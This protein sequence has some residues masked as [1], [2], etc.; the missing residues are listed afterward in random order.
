[1]SQNRTFDFGAFRN[2]SLLNRQQFKVTTTGIYAGYNVVI[3]GSG[4]LGPAGGAIKI[5]NA[6]DLTSVAVSREGV[7]IEESGPDPIIILD[8][9]VAVAT[10]SRIDLVVLQ[11]TFSSSNNPATYAVIAGTPGLNPVPPSIPA[12]AVVLAEVNIG[13]LPITTITNDQIVRR[14]KIL[15]DLNTTGAFRL[16]NL[17]QERHV[18]IATIAALKAIPPEERFD[19]QTVIVDDALPPGDTSATYR[20]D[21][22]SAATADDPIIVSPTNFALGTAGRWIFQSYF[23]EGKFIAM[24]AGNSPTG[25]F[26]SLPDALQ[27][28]EDSFY[29]EALIIIRDDI[30]YAGPD[31]TV[32]KPIKFLGLAEDN[33]T[34]FQGIKLIHESGKLTFDVQPSAVADPLG[35]VEF[36]N[37]RYTRDPLADGTDRII[38]A[39]PMNI[40]FSHCVL[41]D[42]SLATATTPAIDLVGG[43][44]HILAEKTSFLNAGTV[45][46]AL[47]EA[48]TAGNTIRVIMSESSASAVATS[49]GIFKTTGAGV[50]LITM[51]NYSVFSVDSYPN[52]TIIDLDGTSLVVGKTQIP[53]GVGTLVIRGDNYYCLRFE[54]SAF[55]FSVLALDLNEAIKFFGGSVL[56]LS[57]ETF[58]LGTTA[59]VTA[60]SDI[61]VK[62][63]KAGAEGTR[64]EGTPATT[65]DKV[66]ELSG[67]RVR[68]EGI[69]F[70]SSPL[71]AAHAVEILVSPGDGIE[72]V[73]CEFQAEGSNP[74]GRA[75]TLGAT[76]ALEK[77]RNLIRNCLIRSSPDGTPALFEGTAAIILDGAGSI[78]NCKVKDFT[79]VGISTRCA[80]SPEN[81]GA[82]VSNCIVDMSSVLTGAVRGIHVQGT[83]LINCRVRCPNLAANR[84]TAEAIRVENAG[85]AAGREGSVVSNCQINGQGTASARRIGIGINIGANSDQ[86]KVSGC[87]IKSCR[88]QGIKIEGDLSIV[89]HNIITSIDDGAAGGAAI[90]AVSGA[91]D[92]LVS[93]NIETATGGTPYVDGGTGNFFDTTATADNTGNKSV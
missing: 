10:N 61:T 70:R 71:V 86:C 65:T 34:G 20:F 13:P 74:T 47:I 55:G 23:N 21:A 39:A 45:G 42:A 18:S 6:P 84:D 58:S 46:E 31:V 82:R 79:I 3:N 60:R 59:I 67:D 28:F 73:D 36:E 52:N 24:L 35:R 92:N 54:D 22:S 37:I 26:A 19:G 85:D 43:S 29:R 69:V 44:F 72:I 89:V 32:S 93:D 91:D 11:H 49:G 80:S 53:T 66:V 56:K 57:D 25:D 2:T 38:F 77:D 9:G 15:A 7:R 75:L 12:D 87:S 33:S 30:T 14:S 81:V 68:F 48:T 17:E 64:I 50:A 5:V 88:K 1:M 51:A 27:A 4:T 90:E 62:G 41:N 8:V 78:E 16:D 40:R 83:L 63:T 76:G